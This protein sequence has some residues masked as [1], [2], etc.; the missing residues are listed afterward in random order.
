MNSFAVSFP[1]QQQS[2]SLQ[3]SQT[4]KRRRRL[5]KRKKCSNKIYRAMDLIIKWVSIPSMDAA[6]FKLISV[7]GEWHM[8]NFEFY[9]ARRQ[10]DCRIRWKWCWI[11]KNFADSHIQFEVGF[12]DEV[13][14][15]LQE[16][17]FPE[18][19]WEFE[20]FLLMIQKFTILNFKPFDKTF[21]RIFVKK[22]PFWLRRR[23]FFLLL[24]NFQERFYHNLTS[25]SYLMIWWFLYIWKDVRGVRG[26]HTVGQW[27]ETEL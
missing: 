16:E 23:R 6:I 17:Y 10:S 11:Q 2:Q 18:C 22:Y 15:V 7:V 14:T 5:D 12:F 19:L 27:K 24:K 25:L 4:V 21:L 3:L 1:S 26:Y 20:S 13:I 8:A 9:C